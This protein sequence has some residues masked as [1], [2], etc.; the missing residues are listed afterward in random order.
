MRIPSLQLITAVIY[1]AVLVSQEL[2]D[3][4]ST[5]HLSADVEKMWFYFTEGTEAQC[6]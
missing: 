1:L 4:L 6:Q 5:C 2:W 3:A